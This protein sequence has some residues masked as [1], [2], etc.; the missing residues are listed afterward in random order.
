MPLLETVCELT[1]IFKWVSSQAFRAEANRVATIQF[2]E[3][4]YST[5][6]RLAWIRWWNAAQNR[7]ACVSVR[8]QANRSVIDD[9]A[10]GIRAALARRT[11]LSVD[12]SLARTA[13]GITA[14]SLQTGTFDVRISNE[15]I[16][17]STLNAMIERCTLCVF[18]ARIDRTRIDASTVQAI[19]QFRRR[20]IFIVL[21]DGLVVER[22]KQNIRITIKRARSMWSREHKPGWHTV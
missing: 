3:G 19:A 9:I 2:A 12:T 11:A 20:A 22:C 8:T 21:A 10:Q 18:A 17:A 6:I 7:I 13:L 1:A 16:Q 14:T 5:W 4:V 15:A